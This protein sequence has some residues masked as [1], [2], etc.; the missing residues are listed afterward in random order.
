MLKDTHGTFWRR[1]RTML[2]LT[3]V[4]LLGSAFAVLVPAGPSGAATPVNVGIWEW[5]NGQ[6]GYPPVAVTWGTTPTMQIC[7]QETTEAVNLYPVNSNGGGGGW[8]RAGSTSALTTNNPS[9]MNM[10]CATFTLPAWTWF[11]AGS[12]DQTEGDFHGDS[13]YSAILSGATGIYMPGNGESVSA[14]LG[15][16]YTYGDNVNV[17]SSASCGGCASDPMS[18]S[19]TLPSGLNWTGSGFSGTITQAGSF[20]GTVSATELGSDGSQG[21]TGNADWNFTVNQAANAITVTS[22]V[23]TGAVVGGATYT[24]TATATSGDTVAITIDGSSSSVCSISGGVVSFQ[25]VGTCKLDFND[26]GNSNYVAATQVQQSFSVNKGTSVITVTSSA[27]GSAVVGGVTYTPTATATSGDPVAITVDGSSSA[28][29]SISGGVVSFLAAG[30][31][32][33]D[34]N[35]TGNSNYVAATQV[36]QSLG[37]GKGTNTITITSPAPINATVGGATYTP[38]A[39]ATSGDTVVITSATTSICTISS[40]VVSFLAAGTCT[41]DFNDA[42]NSNYGIAPQQTLSFNVSKGPSIITVTSLAPG[43]AVVGGATYT[44]TATATSGDTVVITSATTS[45]CTISSGVVSFLAAGT[46]TLDFNDAGNSNYSPATQKLQI[47]SVSKGPSIITVTSPAPTGAVVGG[48]TYT[49]TATATSGDTVAITVDGSSSSVCS[50]SGGVVSFQ[51]VGT[52]KLRLQRH[53]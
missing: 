51:A 43:S 22:P 40:G 23:P 36:Q 8:S 37:V 14:G 28:V 26:T 9:G 17:S 34:F 47:F 21:S 44:P 45:I 7:L 15:S 38:T 16:S 3:P 39:T 4:L 27:P 6:A 41:L 35:D 10:Y 48:T 53:G 1:L 11:D 42:G 5:I 32:T 33:L 49:P 12:V 24:P 30:T 52:C 18:V 31:C 50:I 20:S 2:V 13:Q 46:C 25:A 19:G 29:C